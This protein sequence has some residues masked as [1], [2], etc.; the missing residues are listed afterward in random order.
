MKFTKPKWYTDPGHG[1]L[2]VET[3]ELHVLGV[4]GDISGYSYLHPSGKY[5]YLEEDCDATVFIEAY[6]RERYEKEGIPLTD[7]YSERSRI[8]DYPSYYAE[9]VQQRAEFLGL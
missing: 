7:Q 3:L 8:R 1:W 2:R 4:A 6:G 9:Y 5:A